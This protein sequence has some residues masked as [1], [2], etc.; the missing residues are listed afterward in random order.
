[1]M[2]FAKGDRVFA[3]VNKGHHGSLRRVRRGP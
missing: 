3:R 1:V 2:R